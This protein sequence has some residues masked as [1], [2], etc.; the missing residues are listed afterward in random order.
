MQNLV[1]EARHISKHFA[2]VVALD[3][4]NFELRTG[5][6]H[7]LMGENGAGKSTLAKVISGVL[8][9]DA[10]EV[11]YRGQPVYFTGPKQAIDQGIS[12]VMQEF[13]LLPDLDVAENIFINRADYYTGLHL[14]KTDAS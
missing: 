11:I 10:G 14:R 6:I 13:N 9:A 3:N 2:G 1:I 7:A 8:H 5:E 4:V 12:M